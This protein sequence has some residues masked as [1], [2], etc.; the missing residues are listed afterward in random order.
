MADFIYLPPYSVAREKQNRWPWVE[1]DVQ[2]WA[3]VVNASI[4]HWAWSVVGKISFTPCSLPTADFHLSLPFDSP[5]FHHRLVRWCLRKE[6]C[7]E[8]A[9]QMSQWRFNEGDASYCLV[10]PFP[11]ASFSFSQTLVNRNNTRTLCVRFICLVV[12][13]IRRKDTS[14][15]WS[16]A[17]KGRRWTAAGWHVGES[18]LISETQR[19]TTFTGRGHDGKGLVRDGSYLGK[20]NSSSWI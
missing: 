19:D 10:W 6:N 20:D 8:I 1:T 12:A 4:Y 7:P 9:V 14:Y 13:E 18:V 5:I 17:C 16:M 15:T 11:A 2:R 3:G